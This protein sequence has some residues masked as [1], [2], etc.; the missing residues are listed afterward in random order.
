MDQSTAQIVFKNKILILGFGS[1]GQAI[2]PLLFQY[3]KLDPSQI[4]IISKHTLGADVANHYNISFK[5]S[6][7]KENNYQEL[8]SSILKPGDFL[9]NL[10]VGVSTI[11]L[12]KYCQRNNIL[13]LDAAAEPWEERC[14]DKSQLL[15]N[16]ALRDATL[17]HKKQGPTAVLT[18]GAN[19]GLVSHFLKQ[20]LWNVAKDNEWEGELPQKSVEWAQLAHDLNIKTIHISEHDTQISSQIKKPDEFINTWS[21]DALISEALRPA[22]LGW[23]SHERHWP[24]DANHYNF[25]SNCGIYLSRPG[26]ETQVRTWT[27]NSGPINGFLITHAESLSIAEYLTLKKNNKVYYRPTV[28]YAY[29]PCPDAILSLKELV[30]RKYIPQKEKRIILKEIVEGTDELG[31][32]LMGNKKGAYWYGSHLSIHEARK[33]ANHNN[34]TS[35][36][37]A[38]GVLS[39]MIWAIK[40]PERGIIE[41]EDMDHEY[42]LSLA[43]PYLGKV[44]GYYTDW[45]PLQDRGNSNNKDI[46][47]IDPWQFINIRINEGE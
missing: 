28:H 23:G 42:I 35:L 31:V 5:E 9:L 25:G 38:A 12:I 4:H 18:H 2:L 24:H 33:L 41:P 19:P 44:G 34:A 1:I 13:Y 40:N 17:Q 36:Q 20:A 26:A 16:Y 46:D 27:P 39:G 6:A 7:V 37:V 29:H 8:L 15:S 45:T 14:S 43:S 3:F 30:Q 32:L 11:D 21:V 10:S 47:Q 22:E